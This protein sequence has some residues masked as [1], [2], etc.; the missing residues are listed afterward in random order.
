MPTSSEQPPSNLRPPQRQ[1]RWTSNLTDP[2]EIEEFKK[3]LEASRNNAVLRRLYE[4]VV[5]DKT[6]S[7]K[8]ALRGANY[9]SP[10]WAYAQADSIGF[11][12]ALQNIEHLL[13]G[14][15]K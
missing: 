14:I 5:E 13:Q 10:S 6:L 1:S 15:Y 11:Q 3:L 8:A 7:A 2:K 9:D 4:I 12:R